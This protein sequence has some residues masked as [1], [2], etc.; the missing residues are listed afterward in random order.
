MSIRPKDDEDSQD[1][2]FRLRESHADFTLNLE[3]LEEDATDGKLTYRQELFCKC[4]T[5]LYTDTAGNATRSYKKAY[6]CNYETAN[7]NGYRLMV[8]DGVLARIAELNAKVMTNDE[9]DFE[10][11]YVIRQR[12]DL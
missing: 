12:S 6:N 9:A 7:A 1:F 3:E 2:A 4:F 11:A 5:G 8:N 10:L